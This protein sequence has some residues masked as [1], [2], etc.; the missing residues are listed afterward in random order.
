[1]H[2]TH[3]SHFKVLI[4]AAQLHWMMCKTWLCMHPE[5]VVQQLPQ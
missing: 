5:H 2:N 1:M 3:Q 4:A